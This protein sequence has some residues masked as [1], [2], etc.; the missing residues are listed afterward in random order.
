VRV[1]KL[2]LRRLTAGRFAFCPD[3]EERNRGRARN[4]RIT[5]PLQTND[6]ASRKL[7]CVSQWF[8]LLLPNPDLRHRM[9]IPLA[10]VDLNGK[11]WQ[12]E[13]KRKEWNQLSF[14]GYKR[15]SA[16]TAVKFD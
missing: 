13:S 14:S 5:M 4:F 15:Y 8:R 12:Q 6:L 11:P 9:G 16:E 10:H 7:A 1:S 2:F 3:A